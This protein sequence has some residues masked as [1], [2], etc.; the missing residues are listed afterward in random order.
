MRTLIFF[1]GRDDEAR[2]IDAVKPINPI[3]LNTRTKGGE[4]AQAIRRIDQDPDAF[5]VAQIHAFC[6]GWHCP[7]GT[8]ILFSADCVRYAGEA[9]LQQARMREMELQ[10]PKPKIF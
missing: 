10:H 4:I 3:V 1:W 2:V 8:V 9:M 6:T 7:P 5:I